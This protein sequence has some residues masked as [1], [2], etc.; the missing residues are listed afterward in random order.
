[1]CKKVSDGKRDGNVCVPCGMPRRGL[2]KQALS[3]LMISQVWNTRA[4]WYDALA[5]CQR[6]P[7]SC[8]TFPNTFSNQNA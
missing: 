6:I 1:M 5:I 2:N 7:E 3:K 8:F 4:I